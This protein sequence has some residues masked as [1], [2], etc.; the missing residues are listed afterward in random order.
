MSAAAGLSG[1]A[2]G[3][4]TRGGAG[5][6]AVALAVVLLASGGSDI[7]GPSAPGATFARAASTT[8]L[9]PE[10][11]LQGV[12]EGGTGSTTSSTVASGVV[13]DL[14]V[15]VV[16]PDI[17]RIDPKLSLRA[18]ASGDLDRLD[19][20]FREDERVDVF[21]EQVDARGVYNEDSLVAVAIGVAVSPGA[22]ATSGFAESFV[23]GATGGGVINPAPVSVLDQE[24]TSWLVADTGHILWSF[25]NVFLIVSGRDPLLVRDIA[26]AIVTMVI[27][28]A[29]PVTTLP[30]C[31]ENEDPAAAADGEDGAAAD[32]EDGA[33]ADGEAEPAETTVPTCVPAETSTSTTEP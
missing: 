12:T 5:F 25:E 2:M 4:R 30:P 1:D 11:P 14:S 28:P 8:T 13:M 32:G 15:A 7:S 18:L 27:A 31:P 24:L 23:D 22:A 26:E 9:V 29:P 21:L 19:S 16:F 6:G 33:A 17:S 3:K 20:R 10:T